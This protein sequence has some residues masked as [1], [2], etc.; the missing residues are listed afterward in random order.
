VRRFAARALAASLALLAVGCATRGD[1]QREDASLRKL[2]LD[3]KRSIDQVKREVERLRADFE[4]GGI[5]RSKGPDKVSELEQRLAALEGGH[6]APPPPPGTEPTSP[7]ALPPVEGTTT[8]T[9]TPTATAATTETTRPPTPTTLPPP[10][11]AT[12]DDDWSRE[13]AQDQAAVGTMTVPEKDEY[14]GIMSSL[15]RRDC[16]KAV[17]ALNSFAAQKKGSPL[18]SNAIYWT[19]RCYQAKGDQNQAVSKYYDVVTRYPK[20][21][22]AAAALY[23]QGTLFLQMGDTPDARLAFGKLIREHPGSAEATQ[24][25]QKL[26]EI[27]Q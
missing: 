9:T 16:G 14:L 10:P 19:A 7:G 18:A 23:Q 27:E 20:S 21:D 3:Q 24:A 2:I 22:K 15:A 8:A 4:E 1:L 17:P 25:R 12:G 5:K 13:V 26:T 11:A 6:P